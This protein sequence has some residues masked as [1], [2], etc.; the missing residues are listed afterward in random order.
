MSQNPAIDMMNRMRTETVK[1]NAGEA[2]LRSLSIRG[3]LKSTTALVS[4]VPFKG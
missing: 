2:V 3:I 4:T 1:R